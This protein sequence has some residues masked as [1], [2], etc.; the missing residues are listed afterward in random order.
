MLEKLG[1]R[2]NLVVIVNVYTL[3]IPTYIRFNRILFISLSLLFYMIT[4][5]SHQSIYTCRN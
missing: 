2:V 3:G 5:E 4:T 1:C